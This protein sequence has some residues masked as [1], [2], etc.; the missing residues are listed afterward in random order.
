MV[1]G[2]PV[3]QR[4]DRFIV[5]IAALNDNVTENINSIELST[6]LKFQEALRSAFP[7]KT[8]NKCSHNEV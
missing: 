5:S 4:T 7:Y 8:R 2:I 3:G 1:F 6:T